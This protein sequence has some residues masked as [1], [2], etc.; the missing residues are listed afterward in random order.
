MSPPALYHYFNDKYDIL[1]VMARRLLKRQQD[2]YA[3]WLLKG[4]ISLTPANAVE[5]LE[6]WLRIATNIIHS[7]PG[8]I[9]TM[10]TLRALPHLADIRLEAQRQD[11][12]RMFELFRRI[13]PDVDPDVLWCR[14]R[15]RAEFGWTVDELSLEEGRIPRKI[16][17]REAARLLAH[18]L[19][20]DAAHGS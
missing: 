10:R 1:E 15:I 7:E 6:K 11:T 13:F 20:D 18:S 4:G 5:A 9:W 2:A 12:D 14:L 17:L 8:A 19:S 3:A 16:L